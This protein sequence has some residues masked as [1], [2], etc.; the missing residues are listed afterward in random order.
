MSNLDLVRQTS[1]RIVELSEKG[2]TISALETSEQ[3]RLR[4]AIPPLL[5]LL[6][7][8]LGLAWTQRELD[9]C[10]VKIKA[11]GL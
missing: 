6:V 7:H 5:K 10:A 1:Q 8:T 9:A 11:A 4:A 3:M 2:M